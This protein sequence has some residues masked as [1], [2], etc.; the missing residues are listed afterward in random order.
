MQ[1]QHP[2]T[3]NYH[4][5]VVLPCYNEDKAIAK[6]IKDFKDVLP[7]ADIHVFDNNST[8]R[9]AE[10]ARAAGARVSHVALKGKGNVVRRMFADVEADIYLMTDG[11]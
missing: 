8:D 11:D 7:E 3:A 1:A 4:I 10:V 5:A 6:V 2:D 9:T